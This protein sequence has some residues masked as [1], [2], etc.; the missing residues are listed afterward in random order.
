MAKKAIGEAILKITGNGITAKKIYLIAVQ[1]AMYVFLY[2]I[3]NYVAYLRSIDREWVT[4]PLID[5]KIPFLD[6]F[7]WPYISAYVLNT[8]GVFL[9]TKDME[10]QEFKKI[11][12]AY[13]MNLIVLVGFYFVIPMKAVRA[14]FDPDGSY[15][16]WAVNILHGAMFPYNTFPSA[17]VSYSFLTGLIA[18]CGKYKYRAVIIIDSI[19]II[20]STL[21]IKE[22]VI[23][24]V[25][26][27]IVLA[28]ICYKERENALRFY[29][30]IF[31]NYLK[32]GA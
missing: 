21:F 7:V 17:H 16:L 3:T 20:L 25:A 10:Y 30:Y 22:H 24:D 9:M 15:S 11:T 26:T 5:Y 2:Y 18:Y 6:F 28:V 27:G 29:K 32:K 19:L 23:V 12:A 1:S 14:D 13:F 8:V 4:I 31:K